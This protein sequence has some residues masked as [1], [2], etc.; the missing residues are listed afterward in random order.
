MQITAARVLLKTARAMMQNTVII[1]IHAKNTK[2]RAAKVAAT[3]GQS[4]TQNLSPQIKQRME[5]SHRRSAYTTS[6]Q[7]LPLMQIIVRSVF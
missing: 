3:N 6:K 2:C 5:L 4:K 1:I 7:K